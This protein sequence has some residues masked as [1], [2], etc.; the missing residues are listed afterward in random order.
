M[1][2]QRA[3]ITAVLLACSM[4]LA[5]QEKP[6][7]KP[8]I[9][10]NTTLSGTF[11]LKSCS[12]KESI[13]GGLC[14]STAKIPRYAAATATLKDGEYVWEFRDPNNEYRCVITSMPTSVYGAASFTVACFKKKDIEPNEVSDGK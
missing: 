14:I 7:D 12:E 9:T 4:S 2:G 11:H 1:R 10:D 5:A 8:K 6:Q 13:D 3:V